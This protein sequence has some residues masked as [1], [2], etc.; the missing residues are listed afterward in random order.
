MGSFIN[1][2]LNGYLSSII[3]EQECEL[4]NMMLNRAKVLFMIIDWFG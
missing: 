3:N 1:K 2:T 4:L